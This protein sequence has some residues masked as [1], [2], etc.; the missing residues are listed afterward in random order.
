MTK[1]E[2]RA[3][4]AEWTKALAEGRILRVG[5][6]LTSYPTI[7]ARDAAIAKIE[8]GGVTVSIVTA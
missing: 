5:N 8:R 1:R 3:A 7:E 4:R 2:Y 6:T